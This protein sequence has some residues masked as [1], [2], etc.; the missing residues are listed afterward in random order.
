MTQ[1]P[2]ENLIAEVLASAKYRN[3]SPDVVRV[4]GIRELTAQRNLRD[5][6]KATKNKLHQVGGSY[7]DV[8]P[9]YVEWMDQLTAASD[10]VALQMACLAIMQHHASTRERLVILE[11]FYAEIFAHLP[12]IHVVLDVACGMNPLAHAWMPL[13]A[14][15][16]YLACDIYADMVGLVNAFL[17]HAKINGRAWVCDLVSTPP[18]EEADLVLALKV[19]P[20]LEQIEKGAAL[21]LLQRLNA[22]WIVVSF[23]AHSLGGRNKGMAAHYE[24]WLRGIVAGET[25]EMTKLSFAN[26]VVFLVR[27]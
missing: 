21:R 11:R 14:N 6:I 3:V 8:K 18:S 9:D 12:P 26:E 17:T 25:W 7:L 1:S 16:R 15:S 19:L 13:A 2:L 5:A 24:Q 23:P 27:K 4:I 22:P 10:P 20:V